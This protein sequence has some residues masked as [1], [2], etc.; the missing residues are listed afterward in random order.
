M[1]KN[2]KRLS[3]VR[4]F[5]SLF[6]FSIFIPNISVA[7]GYQKHKNNSSGYRYSSWSKHQRSWG[8]GYWG[9]WG[10]GD[11]GY[12]APTPTGYDKYIT[13]MA[14]G[15]YKSVD[16]SILVDGLFEGDGLK[17]QKYVMGRNNAEIEAWKQR[18]LDFFME[19]FGVD[20]IDNED[21]YFTGYQIDPK[22][23]YRAFTISDE[24]VPSSGWEVFD[25]GYVALVTNPDGI[26]LGG[27]YEGVHVPSGA[28]LVFG[29]YKIVSDD[30]WKKPI[31]LRYQSVQPVI[32][33]L[34]R[35]EFF[36]PK[37]GR[38]LGGGVNDSRV[39][40][41]GVVHG[42]VNVVVTFSAHGKGS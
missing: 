4:L 33:G 37:Y 3:S 19:R 36:S 14:N 22:L 24:S 5:L 8:G 42:Q 21:F 27:E 10:Y 20:P 26:T 15:V 31:Y 7:D 6:F 11:K 12:K 38:G 29:E 25:G 13:L 2:Q 28:Q 1:N 34:I 41:D 35:C 40:E 17:F 23:D 39:D 9:N 30:Y 16:G 18:A 32:G